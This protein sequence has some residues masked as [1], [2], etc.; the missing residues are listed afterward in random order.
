MSNA[1]SSFHTKAV[2]DAQ[3]KTERAKTERERASRFLRELD[4][5]LSEGFSEVVE[6]V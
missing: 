4:D 2:A 5:V 1:I 6:A 3:A